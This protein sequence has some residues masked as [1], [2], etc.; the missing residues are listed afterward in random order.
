MNEHYDWSEKIK[1]FKK[2]HYTRFYNDKF[3]LIMEEPIEDYYPI[4]LT[5]TK[6]YNFESITQSNCVRTY[7]NKPESVIFSLRHKEIDSGRRA[8][9]EYRIVE[10]DDRINLTR[11][12][13]LGKF[14]ERLSDDWK[15]ILQQLDERIRLCCD[16]EIFQLPNVQIKYNSTIIDTK[17]VFKDVKS[18]PSLYTFYGVKRDKLNLKQLVFENTIEENVNY[19]NTPF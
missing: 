7:D 1:N 9:I 10:I 11:V 19:E 2:S 4:L 6:E 13:T 17:I 12:Q 15:P 5:T 14:N 8:T 3:K 18:E 16:N